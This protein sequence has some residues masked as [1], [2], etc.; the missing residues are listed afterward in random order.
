MTAGGWYIF[1]ASM[2]GTIFGIIASTNYFNLR[3]VMLYSQEAIQINALSAVATDVNL[4]YPAANALQ[5]IVVLLVTATTQKCVATTAPA[6]GLAKLEINLKAFGFINGVALLPGYLY[7][8][9]DWPLVQTNVAISVN[10]VGNTKQLCGIMADYYSEY[11]DVSCSIVANQIIIEQQTIGR[12]VRLCGVEILSDCNCAL[13]S[14]DPA[15]FTTIP[16]AT[17]VSTNLISKFAG[18]VSDKSVFI[19]STIF[20]SVS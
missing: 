5:N 19:S 3:E 20:D 2:T 14:F 13:S 4:N 15:S 12:D 6:S 16:A 1:S 9:S 11:T 17:L 8:S 18:D 7:V 10:K